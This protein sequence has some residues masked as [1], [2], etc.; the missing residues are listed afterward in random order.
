MFHQ[1][2]LFDDVWASAHA[3][4]ANALLRFARRWDVLSDA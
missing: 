2:I 1:W 3:D 4:L